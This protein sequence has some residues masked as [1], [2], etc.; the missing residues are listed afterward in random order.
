[1]KKLV[2]LILC[3]TLLFSAATYAVYAMIETESEDSE[4][5]GLLFEG[6]DEES[7]EIS[8]SDVVDPRVANC[9]VSNGTIDWDTIAKTHTGEL[10]I[11]GGYSGTGLG[12]EVRCGMHCIWYTDPDALAWVWVTMPSAFG[13]NPANTVLPQ[14]EQIAFLTNFLKENGRPCLDPRIIGEDWWASLQITTV[15]SR[16]EI[17]ELTPYGFC[18]L[19]ANGPEPYYVEGTPDPDCPNDREHRPWIFDNT[20]P[21]YVK[22]FKTHEEYGE[23]LGSDA[24]KEWYKSRRDN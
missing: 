16:K 15:L 10:S 13:W 20:L 18:F 1:M 21:E 8:E 9:Y 17:E 7:E 4:Q 5:T 19:C 24:C 14:E 23:W 11:E 22:D 12:R 2:L 3:L 6:N